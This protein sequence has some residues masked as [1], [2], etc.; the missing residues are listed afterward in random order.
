MCLFMS[1][2]SLP[3]KPNRKTRFGDRCL[4]MAKQQRTRL[5]ILRRCVSMLLCWHDHSISD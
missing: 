3:T 2:S 1:N 5:Y 4:L